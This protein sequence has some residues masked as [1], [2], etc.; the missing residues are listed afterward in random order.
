MKRALDA[1]AWAA[2]DTSALTNGYD[3]YDIDART[4]NASGILA[5]FQRRSEEARAHDGVS[6]ATVP[7]ASDPLAVADIFTP[8]QGP[9]RGSIVFIHGGYWKGKGRPN[10]AFLAPAWVDVGV[11]WIN[12]GYPVA[13]DMSMGDIASHIGGALRRILAGDPPFGLI[14][15]PIVLSGNSA[16][17]H[18][19]AHALAHELPEHTR[20]RVAGCL[21][22]SGLYDLRPLLDTPANEWM[23]LNDEQAFQLSPLCHSPPKVRAP[24]VVTVGAEEPDAFIAQSRAYAQSMLGYAN[25]DY[26]EAPALNHLTMIGALDSPTAPLGRIM[27]GWLGVEPEC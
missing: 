14:Q 23:R 18:L 26:Q 4:P 27:A 5:D 16:G 8:K 2:L 13:P 3:D 22:L 11:Q 24:V 21:L 20:K 25:V 17:A 12:L 19:V 10:R 15:G 1:P 9:T 7:Y 6:L